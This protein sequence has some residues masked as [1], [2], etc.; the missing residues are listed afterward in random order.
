MAVKWRESSLGKD[1]ED[2]V[3]EERS[4]HHLDGCAGKNTRQGWVGWL[5]GVHSFLPVSYVISRPFFSNPSFYDVD[6]DDD[7]DEEEYD[8]LGSFSPPSNREAAIPP[9]QWDSSAIGNKLCSAKSDGK[10]TKPRNYNFHSSREREIKRKRR[11]KKGGGRGEGK[12][13]DLPFPAAR[14]FFNNSR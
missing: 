3:Q 6:D 11:R 1:S 10:M 7:D 12:K 5:V 8:P 14:S 13:E 9:Q 4:L 2:L